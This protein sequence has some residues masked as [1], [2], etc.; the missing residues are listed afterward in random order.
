MKLSL[1]FGLAL[2]AAAFLIP[3]IMVEKP[4]GDIMFAEVPAAV[5]E[6]LPE[7]GS[8]QGETGEDGKQPLREEVAHSVFDS[9]TVI[10]LQTDEGIISISLRDYLRGVLAAEMPVTF[11][12]EALK[13]QA[14]TARTYA[15]YRVDRGGVHEGA[16]VCTDYSHCSAYVSDELLREKWAGEYEEKAARIQ[17]AVDE[18][19]GMVIKYG[20]ELIDAVFHSTSSG[21]TEAAVDVWGTERPYLQSVPSRGEESAPRF[22]GSVEIPTGELRELLL[23][24]IPLADL[25]VPVSQ[26]FSDVVRSEAGSVKSIA[27]GG[28]TVSGREIRA[29]LGLNSANFTVTAGES[30][31]IFTTVGYGHGVGMSQYGANYMAKTG[32]T[33][34]EILEHY[35]SGVTVESYAAP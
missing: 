23:G 2:T 11:E 4:Q 1:V 7:D 21:R 12:P 28:E 14:A 33:Y 13:A 6:S 25:S 29:L 8:R 24:V 31:F 15:L 27:V 35:Y 17:T 16:D 3:A 20:S 30:K 5:D 9:N 18:T 22:S 19:D 26:W 34:I 10:R 32:S